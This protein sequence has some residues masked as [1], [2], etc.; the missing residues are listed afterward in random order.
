MD[1]KRRVQQTR[2]RVKECRDS[3]RISK[4]ASVE[5]L[6][7]GGVEEQVSSPSRRLEVDDFACSA[8]ERAVNCTAQKALR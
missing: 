7:D 8:D 3:I 5:Q 4:R 1:E 6:Q 2:L